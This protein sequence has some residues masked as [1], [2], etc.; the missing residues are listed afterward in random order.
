MIRFFPSLKYLCL[1]QAIRRADDKQFR[2]LYEIAA[3]TETLMKDINI[4]W[5]YFRSQ[6]LIAKLFHGLPSDPTAPLRHQLRSPQHIDLLIPMI[7]SGCAFAG[8]AYFSSHSSLPNPLVRHQLKKWLL[9]DRSS[10]LIQIIL[11]FGSY[12][13]IST[14]A[15][16]LGRMRCRQICLL[17]CS[18]DKSEKNQGFYSGLLSYP[19]K[20]ISDCSHCYTFHRGLALKCYVGQ[21]SGYAVDYFNQVKQNSQEAIV[22][23]LLVA[24]RL[25][26]HKDIRRYIARMLFATIPYDEAWGQSRIHKRIKQ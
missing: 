17:M 11:S 20:R 10:L 14:S 23:W 15:M 21:N 2:M 19:R 9:R 8:Q 18:R 12:E 5:L 25:R 7:S 24:K 16:A 6:F 13:R 26:I 3:T 1:L 22:T 4:S